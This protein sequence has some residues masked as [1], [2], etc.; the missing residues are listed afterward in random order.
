MESQEQQRDL[1]N[2]F[3]LGEDMCSVLLTDKLWPEVRQP[4]L[5]L[6]ARES[7]VSPRG[8]PG[9]ACSLFALVGT[10]GRVGK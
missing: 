7:S 10:H 2:N 1:I 8:V 4:A 3:N 5:V 6:G 9:Y